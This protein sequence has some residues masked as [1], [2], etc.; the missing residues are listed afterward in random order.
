MMTLALLLICLSLLLYLSKHWVLVS[1]RDRDAAQQ[2]R[3]TGLL[4]WSADGDDVDASGDE[5][6]ARPISREERDKRFDTFLRS[7]DQD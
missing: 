3:L 7:S 5:A 6:A 1:V 2:K 4:N